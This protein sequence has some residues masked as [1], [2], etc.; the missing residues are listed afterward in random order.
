MAVLSLKTALEAPL[1]QVSPH[2]MPCLFAVG[3]IYPPS[4]G[5]VGV[6]SAS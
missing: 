5:P 3:V 1:I 6:A 2:I 4:Q